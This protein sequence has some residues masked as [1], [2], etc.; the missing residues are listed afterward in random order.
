MNV[1]RL[2]GGDVYGVNDPGALEAVFQKIDQ[3]QQTKLV[4]LAPD[5]LDDFR[6]Y[7][8]AGMSLVGLATLCLFGVRFTPW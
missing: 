2:T 1:A 3:M 4:Q 7:C 5:T 6:P 8:L